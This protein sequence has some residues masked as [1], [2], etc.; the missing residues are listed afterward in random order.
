[1]HVRQMA[2]HIKHTRVLCCPAVWICMADKYVTCMR[3]HVVLCIPERLL[4]LVLGGYE[5]VLLPEGVDCAVLCINLHLDGVLQ[6]GALQLGHLCCHG[7]REELRAPLPRDHL[8]D[9]VDLLLEIHVQQPIRLIQH[10]MPQSLQREALWFEI[11]M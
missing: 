1:M 6:A 5:E 8:E 10:Q 11:G 7:G 9:L 2:P 4:H 3:K